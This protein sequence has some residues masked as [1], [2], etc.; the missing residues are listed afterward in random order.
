[1]KILLAADGSRFS[2]IAALCVVQ[3]AQWLA[4]PPVVHLLHVHAPLPYAG[5]AARAGKGSGENYQREESR[6]A[7][8]VAEVVLAAAGVPYV[9]SWVVGNAADEIAAHVEKLGSDLVV[10]GS[11]GHGALATLMLGSV[12]AKYI[13]SAE[14]PVLIAHAAPRAASTRPRREAGDSEAPEVPHVLVLSA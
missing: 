12:T 5:A 4:E 8:A 10:M 7:L 9:S 3:H 6:A 2:Q 11:H 14:V 1:M 13:A